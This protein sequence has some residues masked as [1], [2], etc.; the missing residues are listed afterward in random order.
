[1]EEVIGKL[2]TGKKKQKKLQDKVEFQLKIYYNINVDNKRY[3][4]PLIKKREEDN[5]YDND[6]QK[7]RHISN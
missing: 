2:Y 6:K 5:H 7:N 3:D 4:T 1:M